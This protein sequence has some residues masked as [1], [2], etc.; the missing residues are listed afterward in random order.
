MAVDYLHEIHCSPLQVSGRIHGK[1][2]H[3]GPNTIFLNHEFIVGFYKVVEFAQRGS[4]INVATPVQFLLA[5]DDL[6][7]ATFVLVIGTL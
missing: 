1:T 7:D 6:A 2:N 5:L 3:I 4:I